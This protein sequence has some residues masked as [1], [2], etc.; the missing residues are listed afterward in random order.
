MPKQTVRKRSIL[1]ALMD[2]EHYKALRYIA[3]KEQRS[4][5][6][7]AREAIGRYIEQKF[8]EGGDAQERKS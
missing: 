4:I 7:V 2:E 1:F 8:K 3:Y 6:D 5:A